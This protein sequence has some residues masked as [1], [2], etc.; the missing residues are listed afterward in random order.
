M[1]KQ[2]FLS[3]VITGC[4]C[5]VFAVVVTALG[6]LVTLVPGVLIAFVSGFLGSLIA[7][8]VMKERS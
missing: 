2:I 1:T 8:Y 4:F 6:M 7:G 5:A 3:A